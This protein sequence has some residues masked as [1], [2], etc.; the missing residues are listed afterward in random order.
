[1]KR[2]LLPLL[3]M[4]VS[5]VSAGCTK[6]QAPPP[7]QPGR[8][9]A[10]PAYEK[11][12]GP[13]PTTDKGTCFAFVI[14]FPSAREAGKVV[15]FPFFTFDEASIR[16]VAVERLLGGMDIGSYKGEFLQPFPAGTRVAS[17]S[18]AQ[19]T[20]T[21]TLS[22]GVGRAMLDTGSEPAAQAIALTLRQFKGVAAVRIQEEGAERPLDVQADESAI[23]PPGPPRLLSVTAMKD[24]GAK[25]VEEVNAFFDRPVEI[26]TLKITDNAGE[27]FEG[28]V[29]HSV[30]DMAAVMKPRQPER[31]TA[32]MPV[33]VR[34]DVADKLGRTGRGAETLPLEVREHVD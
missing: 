1:M 9:S 25:V 17:I 28:D 29:Y 20:V 23:L 24:K 21:L 18:E 19:G 32:G 6:K 34:W 30:F 8:I 3:L 22:R 7:A 16:K 31:F 4:L 13:A 26:T 15:P 10:T 27:P 12:F 11:Y 33:Q 5:L 14:Y 2:T